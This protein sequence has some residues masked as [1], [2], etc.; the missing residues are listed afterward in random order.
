MGEVLLRGNSIM[1]G[2]L[3]NPATTE[4]SFYGEWYHTGD[5]G[6]LASGWLRG[7][8]GPVKGRNHFRRLRISRRLKSRTCSIVIRPSWMPPSWPS[9]TRS[10]ARRPAPS[11]NW[12]PTP[13]IRALM[14]SSRIAGKI[15]PASRCLVMW[16]SG[17][18]RRPRRAKSRNSGCEKWRRREVAGIQGRSDTS[19]GI[20]MTKNI[21]LFPWFKFC[22][23]LLFWQATWFLYFQ[24]ELSARRSD[25]ALCGLRHRNDPVRGSVRLY[26]GPP[27]ATPHS[28]PLRNRGFRWRRAPRARRWLCPLCA[29]SSTARCRRGIRVRNRQRVPLRIA[30]SQRSAGRD[31]TRGVAGLAVFLC[32]AGH[33]GR[34]R[35]RDGALCGH[36]SVP[37]GRDRIRRHAGDI[38]RLPGTAA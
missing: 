24:Q 38:H 15:W 32:G 5:P 27:R 25:P 12:C 1:K 8:Q 20:K 17:P 35:R 28:G 21:T 10:G 34:S 29:G 26:V 23:N 36:A 16:S 37:I 3:D 2:Y 7:G 13:A 14:T 9:R 4:N 30:G 22:Q 31:R 11:S 6:G 18:C 19:V 33:I